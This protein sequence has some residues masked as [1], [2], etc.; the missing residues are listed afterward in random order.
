[1]ITKLSLKR[2]VNKSL[3]VQ[4]YIFNGNKFLLDTQK[5]NIRLVHSASRIERIKDNINFLNKN[6]SMI[7]Q[8]LP[9]SV[10]INM[11]IN[12][13]SPRIIEVKNNTLERNLF[14]WWN[15]VWWS[16]P[17]ERSYGRQIRLL[18]WDDYHNAPMGLINL[19]SP[20]ISWKHRDEYLNL[21]Y[22]DKEFWINQSMNAQRIG[23]LP[24]YNKILGGKLIALLMT[25]KDVVDIYRQKYRDS[26][27]HLKKRYIPPNLLFITTTGAF[28][29]SS[30]YNRL[31]DYNNNFICQYLGQTQGCGSFHIP[32]TL[33]DSFV[34]YLGQ[35]GHNTNRGFGNGPSRKMRII[36]KVMSNLGYKQG[37]LHG[38]KRAVYIFNLTKNIQDIIHNN[39]EPIWYNREI[40]KLTSH[41]IDKWATKRLCQ[42]EKTYFNKDK[43]L[44]DTKQELSLCTSI[45]D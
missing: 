44:Q 16:L 29:K 38:V 19:Q 18:I 39:Q 2:K 13:I 3:R 42:P 37:A 35:S 33:Y 45:V 23:A 14:R 9:K 22:K 10:D 20:I 36:T 21:S 15:L 8:Y 34:Q 6:T 43:F 25:S 4:G 30:V 12:K 7:E 17:Y 11:N 31:K 41:W 27:T 28:G 40:D 24:P 5:T 26:V 1:M 32:L